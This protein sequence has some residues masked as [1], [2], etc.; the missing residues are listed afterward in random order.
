MWINPCAFFFRSYNGTMR[1]NRFESGTPNGEPTNNP[2]NEAIFEDVQSELL[3]ASPEKQQAVEARAMELLLDTEGGSDKQIE[4]GELSE[5]ALKGRSYLK[6]KFEAIKGFIG[7]PI[8]G[9]DEHV[10]KEKWKALRHK[11][12]GAGVMMT[13][14]AIEAAFHLYPEARQNIEEMR[15][16]N[17]SRA[18]TMEA[19]LHVQALKMAS[20]GAGLYLLSRSGLRKELEEL[21]A[22]KAEGTY[23]YVG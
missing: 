20:M 18:S 6:E 13:G 1:E 22:A 7:A 11:L 21:K 4:Q 15:Q 17:S 23:P 16:F 3:S 8:E 14:V 5:S 10:R 9:D 2:E 12:L 19:I